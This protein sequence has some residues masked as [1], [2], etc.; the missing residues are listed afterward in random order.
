MSIISCSDF[1]T[2]LSANATNFGK[3]IYEGI[4]Y[5]DLVLNGLSSSDPP[6]PQIMTNPNLI[7]LIGPSGCGKST[8]TAQLIRDH[9]INDYVTIDPDNAREILMRNG[10]VFDPSNYEPMSMITNIYNERIGNYCISNNYN[11]ILDTTGRNIDLT[12]RII[13]NARNHST[14]YNI[15]FACI[16]A[17]Y[18]TCQQRVDSRNRYIRENG[19]HRI[20]LGLNIARGIYADFTNP[21]G[22]LGLYYDNDFFHP[23]ELL[24]Y[25]ND[26][27]ASEPVLLYRRI[28]PYGSRDNHVRYSVDKFEPFYCLSIV[29]GVLRRMSADARGKNSRKRKG[30]RTRK[31]RSS[32]K[33]RKTGK[34]R[35]AYKKLNKREEVIASLW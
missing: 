11:I 7:I 31:S 34:R 20:Q 13:K 4:N 32:G 5:D 18:E 35:V 15:I 3:V 33:F 29:R 6:E 10:L 26:A 22:V 17:S 27:D 8:V 1:L 24:L 12:N 30:N 28:K 14:Q 2:L 21:L 19:L 25:N 23:H 16:Y 9:D